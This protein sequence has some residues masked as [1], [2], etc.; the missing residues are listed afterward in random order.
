MSNT[1][2]LVALVD[3]DVKRTLQTLAFCW[4]ISTSRLVRDIL[5][6]SLAAWIESSLRNGVVH[7]EFRAFLQ[8]KMEEIEKK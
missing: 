7:P 1:E 5:A 6:N 4:D 2:R 3:G 8:R